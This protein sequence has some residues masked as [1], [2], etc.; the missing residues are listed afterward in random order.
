MANKKKVFTDESL[1]TLVDETKQYVD[2]AV[3]GKA[4]V[5]HTHNYAGSSSA[6]GAATSANKLNTN[7]GGTTQPVYFANGVPVKTTYTLGKSV[8]SNAV[9]T[10]THYASKNVVGGTTATTNTTTALT[11]G[12]VYLN[13][14][15]NGA[16][17]STHKISG[18]GATTVTTDTSGNIIISSTDNNTT[19]SAAGSSLGLVKSGGDVTISSGTITVNDDSHN[20]TIANIDDLQTTIDTINEEIDGSIKGLSVSGTTITYT[21]NDGTTGTITTQDTNT[22]YSTATSSALGLV[23]I[24]YTESGKNYP[25]ELNSSG[26]M[27]V[28]VPWTDNN[29]TYSAATTSAAGLMSSSDKIKLNSIATGANNYSLP[30]ASSSTLGGVK[31]TST[32]TSASGLTA[33]PIISGV[34]YYKD[35]NTTYSSL[36]NPYSLTIQANGTSLGTYDGSAAKTFNL[37]YSNVGAAASSH[38]HSSYLKLAGGTMTGNIFTKKSDN[39]SGGLCLG[40]KWTDGYSDWIDTYW[41]DGKKHQFA[42]RQGDGLTSAFGWSGSSSYATVTYIRGRTCQYSNSSGTTTLSDRNLKEDIVEFDEKYD[43]F[44]DNLKPTRYKYILGS[45]GRHHSGFITQEVESA[46]EDA[47]LTTKDFG[48][49]NIRPIEYYEQDVEDSSVNYLL[50]KGIKEEHNLIYTEF[51]AL[52]TWQIQKLKAENKELKEKLSALENK[53]LDLEEKLNNLTNN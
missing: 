34:P 8:P 47:G 39:D 52:N 51:V 53:F 48:G 2:N 7:A 45:S 13:S 23:K 22:T 9:F 42:Q 19:Y 31:T 25:V 27:Y 11:N 50:D 44:F 28:N 4:N 18:S 29:T 21:K 14:V 32:V 17:T 30:T 36:K 24:G 33:C 38:S 26:Q 46:L 6:G 49:V 41:K 1:A 10:D 3:S 37:T 40:T 43:A 12:N 35:T 5:S 20:H 15:E 16:V